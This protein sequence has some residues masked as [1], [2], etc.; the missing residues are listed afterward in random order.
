M[1]ESRSSIHGQWSSKFIFILAATGSAVGL[2][3]IWKFPYITGDNGGG[4]F[5]LVYLL[6]I[7]VIGIPI[8]MAEV[9]LGRRGRQSPINT[10]RTLARE[11]GASPFWK[12]IG[13]MGV[14]AG[15]LIL[16]YYSVIA[17]WALAYVFRAAGGAFTG[18]NG[19]EVQRLFARLVND[20]ERLLAWH[21]LFMLMTTL[22]VAR[23]VRGGLEKAVRILM[24]LL[25]VILVILVGYAMNTGHFEQGLQFLF[26]PDFSRLSADGVLVAMG[27]A[28]FTL[29]LGMG[30][31]MVYGSYLPGK[32]SI[33][34]TTLT[35]AL[36]DTLVAILAAVAIFPIVFANG[37]EPGAGPGLIFQTMPIAFGQMP[38]GILFGTLFFLLLVF[39]AWT[40]AISLIEPAVAWLVENHGFRRFNAAMLVGLLCWSLGLLTVFSFNLLDDVMPLGFLGI[41][42]D[43][44]FFGVFDYLTANIMLPLGGLLIAI[45]AGWILQR[46][47]S[48]DELRL[49]DGL[50]FRGWYFLIRYF[51]P[52]AVGL[53]FLDVAG[54]LDIGG[55]LGFLF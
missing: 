15:F 28:F 34:G 44:T 26:T 41:F 23:G 22:V 30:A 1:A 48:V 20:P 43:K 16:S 40:S 35:I 11:A 51:T 37:L 27:H 46:E 31:I 29:S 3:N 5:V 21:T 53:V 18:A 13:W 50:L 14:I 19:E 47:A 54:V 9:M 49:G 36:L 24:P 32:A 38:G 33:A 4:A 45:F 7:A 39:A 42:H 6:C 17:G 25:F 55:L 12:W 2:G 8:M 10:M 52:V